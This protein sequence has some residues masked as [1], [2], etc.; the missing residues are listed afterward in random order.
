MVFKTI[1]IVF[2][3]IIFGVFVGALVSITSVGFVSGV[4]QISEWRDQF[5]SCFFDFGGY[6]FRIQPLFF[7]LVCALLIIFVKRTLKI[8]RYHGPADVILSA[9]SPSQDLDPK[10][11]FLS[12]FSAVVARMCFTSLQVKL[13]LASNISA[14][15]PEMLG[16]ADEVPFIV[17][18]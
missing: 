11:G 2:Q 5:E 18:V 9:H 7:L 14:T 17:E 1:S 12:T 13:S 6:C 3:V 15:A 4:R 8:A 10:T 16:V